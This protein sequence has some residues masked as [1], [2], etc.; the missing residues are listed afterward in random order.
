MYAESELR[1]PL[2]HMQPNPSVHC[3]VSAPN[4]STA[5][6]VS[7]HLRTAQYQSR[8]SSRFRVSIMALSGSRSLARSLL[9]TSARTSRQVILAVIWQFLQL[10]PIVIWFLG[11]EPDPLSHRWP[12]QW[13]HWRADSTQR[14][15][16]Q[17][18]PEGEMLLNLNLDHYFQF[19]PWF[20]GAGTSCR[21]NWQ[22]RRFPWSQELLAKIGRHGSSGDHCQPWLWGLRDGL[23]GSCH[24][25]GGN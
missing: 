14:D 1:N 15:S 3:T 12:G 20:S 2:Q 4:Q 24:C 6:S 11:A 23:P 22:S 17:F 7:C 21:C 16:L 5:A 25:H 19:S 18:L 8:F 13:S 10:G 9:R